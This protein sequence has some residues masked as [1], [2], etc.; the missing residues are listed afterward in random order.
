MP[1]PKSFLIRDLVNWVRAAAATIS[2]SLSSL[3]TG[4][5]ACRAQ[6]PYPM[7]Q[8]RIIFIENLCLSSVIIYRKYSLKSADFIQFLSSMKIKTVFVNP[9][10]SLF[11]ILS[12]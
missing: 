6:L 8:I 2:F 4:R 12:I 9:C 3:K 10:V 7:S 1:E 5:Y 11:V